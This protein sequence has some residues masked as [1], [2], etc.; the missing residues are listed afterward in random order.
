MTPRNPIK[1]PAD[2]RR[3]H[4]AGRYPGDLGAL[5]APPAS[6]RRVWRFAAVAALL[7]VA[8]AAGW[9]LVPADDPPVAER[10][11]VAQPEV[12]P[13]LDTLEL[14]LIP[15]QM[16]AVAER[17]PVLPGLLVSGGTPSRPHVAGVRTSRLP[18]PPKLPSIPRPS[19]SE[20]TLP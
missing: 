7:A 13:T 19:A 15:E 1:S 2:L 8:C 12:K 5:V 6:S 10:A 20:E 3:L 14:P 11:P 17:R 18:S 4:G 16:P 9:W